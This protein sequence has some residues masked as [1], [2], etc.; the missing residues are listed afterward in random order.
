MLEHEISS[1]F[2]GSQLNYFSQSMGENVDT[3]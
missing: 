1:H 2:D 3:I